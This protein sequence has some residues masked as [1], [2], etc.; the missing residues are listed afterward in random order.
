MKASHEPSMCTS[1]RKSRKCTH[2]SHEA[3]DGMPTCICMI[4]SLAISKVSPF[5]ESKS[6]R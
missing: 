6:P 5:F 4:R 1:V 3:A 2:S